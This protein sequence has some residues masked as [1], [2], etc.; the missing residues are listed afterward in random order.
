MKLNINNNDMMKINKLLNTDENNHMMADF[1]LDILDNNKEIS[2]L[3]VDDNMF[4]TIM[5]YYRCD[6]DFKK[7]MKDLK[8]DKYL[9]CENIDKYTNNPYYKNIKIDDITDGNYQLT[10]KSF[11]KNELFLIDDIDVDDNFIEHTPLAFFNEKFDYLTLSSKDGLWMLISPHEINTMQKA[12]DNAY[13]KVLCL[14]LGLGYFAYMALIKDDVDSVTVIEKDAKIIDLFNKYIFP[15]FPD[16]KFE[17]I[18]A[19]AF[20]YLNNKLDY[21]YCF[22]DLWFDVLDGLPLYM[23]LLKLE[24]NN[25]SIIYDYWIEKSMII[26]ARRCM[27]TLIYNYMSGVDMPYDDIENF[28]D[29]L[30]NDF[31]NKLKDVTIYSF[32]DVIKLLDDKY[33]KE[34]LKSI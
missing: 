27:F 31:D 9:K 21:D 16:K 23:K 14:G 28:Y 1:I 26:M 30:I 12:I 29:V 20:T 33:L 3:V 13:G 15:C 19:D 22:A 4:D 5:K 17:I 7:Q 8:F 2:K 34:L 10:H 24:A 18:N 25:P 11:D 32:G 6:K